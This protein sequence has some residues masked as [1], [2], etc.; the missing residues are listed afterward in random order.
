MSS[1][2]SYTSNR[3][4][5]SLCECGQA[6]K[7]RTSWTKNNPAR[8]FVVC[9]NS[10]VSKSGINHPF[11]LNKVTLIRLC[12]VVQFSGRKCGSFYWLDSEVNHEWYKMVLYELYS[13]LN[14]DQRQIYHNMINNRMRVEDLETEVQKLQLE[15]KKTRSK[16]IFYRKC[17]FLLVI[18][19]LVVWLMF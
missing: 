16:W 15:L 19:M 10:S 9:P 12:I 6:M 1:S 13:S 17:C 5:P 14:Q 3:N 11:L 8:R 7:K 2:T 18:L 4:L